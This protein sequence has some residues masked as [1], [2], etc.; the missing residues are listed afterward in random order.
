MQQQDRTSDERELAATPETCARQIMELV[1]PLMRLIRTE[2]RQ[3]VS[4]QLSVPQLRVLAYLGRNPG[5]CLADVAGHLGVTNPTASAMVDRLVRRGL[6][7]RA[8]HSEERRRAVLRL[9]AD[10]V[11]LL[12]RARGLTRDKLA[13]ALAT[14]SQRELR[15]LNEGLAVLRRAFALQGEQ[16]MVDERE[17]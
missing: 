16:V 2:M 12:E 5:A 6:V 10:G 13:Q 17:G 9:T 7:E 15:C 8:Q 1:P 11:A 14:L 4:G 3:Q